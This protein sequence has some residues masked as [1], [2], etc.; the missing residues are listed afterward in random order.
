MAEDFGKDEVAREALLKERDARML[1]VGMTVK[2][3]KLTH[4]SWKSG[5]L[6]PVITSEKVVASCTVLATDVNDIS[7]DATAQAGRKRLAPKTAP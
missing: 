6:V 3:G 1:Q 7:N 5:T 2:R 4:T